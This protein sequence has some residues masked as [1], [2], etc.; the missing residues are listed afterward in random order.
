MRLTLALYQP[1]QP[2]NT[3]AML[4]LCA[5]LDLAMDLIEPLGFVW[6]EARVRRV[7][8]D[9]S[10]HVRVKRHRDWD[11]FCA[12]YRGRQ[13]IILLTTRA[14]T[15]YY[16]A[17]F[18]PDDILLVGRESAGVPDEVHA[19]ADLRLT[20]PMQPQCRSL[21]VAMAAGIVAAEARK[22]VGFG[23]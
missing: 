12:E 2:Q 10:Q 6:D 4:R 1:D 5:C 23:N 22:Q 9:Y 14:D 7:A 17:R 21:N 8:M 16:A 11:A 15:P 3:G 19:A 13:R 18:Q 20:I